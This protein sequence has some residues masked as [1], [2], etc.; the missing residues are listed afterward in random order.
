METENISPRNIRCLLI[1]MVMCG[2]LVNGAFT[3]MQDTWIA[4]LLMGVLFFPM[5]LIYSRL[6]ALLPGKNL[7]EMMT[8][9]FGQAGSFLMILLMSLYALVVTA[10]QLRNFTEFT[11]VIALQ[12]TPAIPIMIVLILPVLYL[13]KQGLQVLGRWSLIICAVL[14]I[15]IVLTILFALNVIE[16]S[17]ILPVMDHPFSDIASDAFTIGSIAVGEAVMAMMMMGH[18]KKGKSPYGVYLPGVLMG[19][20]LFALIILRNVCILGPDMEQ[21]AK[22]STYMAVRIID[23][24]S[25][26]ERIESSISFI[27][28]LL[29]ITKMTLF[30][31]A[32]AMGAAWLLKV[33]DYKRLLLPVG[34][35]VL[36]VSALV[37][38]N[39]F[40]MYELTRIY[41][42]F[43]LPFQILIPA[44]IWIA[45]EIKIR[46]HRPAA[47][48]S[49]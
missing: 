42:Y 19:V 20:V 13:A 46:K 5:L 27:Y 4:V 7:Y 1:L 11:V 22:F 48:K 28:V 2:S 30:I 38:N 12:N 8:A 17:H 31:S 32:A 26:F 29:G 16:L 39:V 40:E 14:V 45:A 41:R 36:A 44:V 18:L 25:F 35:L 24:G 47:A 33:S 43:A 23:V 21:A 15:H 34:L 3:V 49:L 6:C 10:L 37:F 9:L